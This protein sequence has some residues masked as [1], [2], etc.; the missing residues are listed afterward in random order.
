MNMRKGFRNPGRE[1][2]GA[3]FW[4]WND[5]LTEGELCRQVRGMRAAGLGGFFMHSRVGLI[6]PYLSKEWMDR[7]R[8]VVREARRVG[9]DAWLYDE[10]R[11][12]SGFA[13]GMVPAK[14]PEYGLKRIVCEERRPGELKWE[15][16]TI[17]VFACTKEGE[18]IGDVRKVEGQVPGAMEGRT[19][20][21]FRKKSDERSDWYNGYG[22]VDLL[23]PKVVDAFIR[24]TH[25]AY[26]GAFQREFGST[27][28]GIF[29]DEP[30]FSQR[31]GAT[32]PWTEQLPA[33]FL[34]RNGYDLLDA[35]PSLFYDHGEHMKVRRDFW[36]AVTDLFIESFSERV[37]EWCDAHRL[38]FTGHYLCEDD[39]TIQTR[40]IG[41]AMP[42]YEYMHVPGI[43]HLG[44]NIHDLI[45]VKQ[46]SSAA[47]Q[48][49]K[50][51]VLSETYGCCGW[52]LSFEDQKWIG[53]WQYCLGVNLLNQH[54]AQYS[55]KGCRK[56]DYPPSINYQ[57]PWWP[58]YR[59]VSDYFA[60]LSYV[61]TRGRL[62]AD[63]LVIHP[64]QSA[65]S[66]YS[67]RDTSRADELNKSFVY[68]SS[69]L[70]EIHRDYDF[71][72][73]KIMAKHGK[74][75]GD[76][77][78]VG[79]SAYRLVIVPPST[80]LRAQTFNLLRQ[81]AE[82]GGKLIFM[83]PVPE[84]IDCRR[85][86]R[87]QQ[88]IGSTRRIHCEK[89]Q[90]RRSIDELLPGDV[91]VQD[92]RAEQIGSIYYQ[93]RI[94]GKAHIY[95]LVNTDQSRSYEATIRLRGE[96]GVEEWDPLKGSI[97]EM[98]CRTE[99]GYTTLRDTFQPT[100]SLLLVLD[101]AKKARQGGQ[102]GETTL[103]TT[104]LQD[105]WKIS[106]RNFNALTLD[107]CQFKLEGEEWG[108]KLPVWKA[109]REAEGSGKKATVSLRYTFRADFTGK[110]RRR[111]YVVM[112]TPER[113]EIR[114]NGKRVRYEGTGWWVDR[115]FKRMDVSK[116]VVNGENALEVTCLFKRP[117]IPGTLIFL[118]GGIEL[119]SVYIIGDFAVKG[120]SDGFVLTDETGT[121]HA[122][123][124]VP[125]GFPFYVG[126]ISYAQSINVPKAQRTYL[127]FDAL[128]AIVTK[129]TV[130]DRTAGIIPW[131]PYRL[132][133]TEYVKAG[134]NVIGVEVVS[135]CRNLLGPHHHRSGELFS[136]G[137]GSFSDEAN[138]T[139]EYSFV[140]FGMGRV[141]LRQ[142]RI[143][144]AGG[145][146]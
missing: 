23:S 44:R 145:H 123:D 65:W 9:M 76:E 16:D 118:K 74:V 144:R 111:I 89:G 7:I 34:E 20:L 50:E 141:R 91:H 61:L 114:F 135:S 2:R 67:P 21:V 58:Y 102:Q 1:F 99:N 64:I 84:L 75:A 112:E 146:P 88:L 6:T 51:R 133:V 127:E 56:R 116:L 40:Y 134:K 19:Y 26:R 108:R 25:E 109:Q 49:G 106:R 15:A 96:G 95:F 4:S 137:P 17:G 28:P 12:P 101:P 54:L 93:H 22:Y 10:D 38:K 136:V 110:G 33:F 83:D 80:T 132:D 143:D 13:G 90:L 53:D 122:G 69:S 128:D 140:K 107:Y 66:V 119:E 130:N 59:H 121:A 81:F 98:A 36:D 3:P 11:W 138:W 55:L 87:L 68:V 41:A 125:Q 120:T 8:A 126:A 31:E 77:I 117:T 115:S 27:I 43:D 105:T 100:G 32:V 5:A 97:R 82:G 29:T 46:V 103:S 70:C 35:L 18:K 129:I 39:L 86:E 113:Y 79:K 63:I 52:N 48:L 72:D 73:E 92:E 142:A 45:T 85:D 71:G 57:Q 62:V 37:Y 24:S 124:L 131:R 94:M 60:R 78:I 30:N 104:D 139:D 47:H 42:H 14:G